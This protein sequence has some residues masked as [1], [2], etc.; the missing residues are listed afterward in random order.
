MEFTNA[1]IASK[2]KENHK[3]AGFVRSDFESVISG[4]KK[5]LSEVGTELTHNITEN[6]FNLDAQPFRPAAKKAEKLSNPLDLNSFAATKSGPATGEPQPPAGL[7][8]KQQISQMYQYYN[9]LIFEKNKESFN[10]INPDLRKMTYKYD[11]EVKNSYM[12]VT[13]SPEVIKAAMGMNVPQAKQPGSAEKEI[14]KP[15]EEEVKVKTTRYSKD[16]MSAIF[17]GMRKFTSPLLESDCPKD[18][19][20]CLGVMLNDK[21]R[22]VLQMMRDE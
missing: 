22:A 8:K 4:L 2:D 10:D 16:Q 17:K 21:P 14:V 9:Y 1:D 19:L 5:Y 6:F 12:T 18:H 13:A 11:N 3:R 15:K 20:P 7:Q